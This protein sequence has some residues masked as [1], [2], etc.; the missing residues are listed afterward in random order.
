[1]KKEAKGS[2]FHSGTEQERPKTLSTN[3]DVTEEKAIEFLKQYLPHKS[4]A[5][6]LQIVRN[7]VSY[8]AIQ[9]RLDRYY[10][11]N[12]ESNSRIDRN[13]HE[14]QEGER[15]R[16][17]EEAEKNR[18]PVTSDTPVPSTV[19]R[20]STFFTGLRR[21]SLLKGGEEKPKEKRDPD[22]DLPPFL[23]GRGK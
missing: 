18:P 5:E 22:S 13:Y 1:M 8:P 21:Q 12:V 4:E 17:Y 16:A 6:L 9:Q 7:L 23:R 15:R 19:S 3:P 14:I 11:E 20:A 2:F 10:R